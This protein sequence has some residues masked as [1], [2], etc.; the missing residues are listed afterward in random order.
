MGAAGVGLDAWGWKGWIFPGRLGHL[1]D[2]V[3]FPDEIQ[4]PAYEILNHLRVVLQTVDGAGQPTVFRS[5]TGGFLVQSL[6]LVV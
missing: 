3:V 2:N 4:F 5:Q 6:A 1:D